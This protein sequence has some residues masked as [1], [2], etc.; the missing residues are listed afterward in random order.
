MRTT[1]DL[2]EE[3]LRQA[4][5]RAAFDGMKLEDL[6]T[7]YV[8]QGLKGGLERPAAEPRRRRSELPVIRAAT[9]RA[10]PALTNADIERILDT[11]E[12]VSGRSD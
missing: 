4:E 12:T 7:R 6:I 8:E 5:R 11:E 10:L 1:I 3:L 2:P 9:G